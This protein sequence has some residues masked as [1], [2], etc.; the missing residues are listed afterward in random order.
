MDKKDPLKKYFDSKGNL[1][2]PNDIKAPKVPGCPKP[3]TETAE[4]S[5]ARIAAELKKQDLDILRKKY[6]DAR[7]DETNTARYAGARLG[8]HGMIAL[9]GTAAILKYGAISGDE[10][11]PAE[12]PDLSNL[13]AEL[14]S[15]IFLALRRLSVVTKDNRDP[16]VTITFWRDSQEIELEAEAEGKTFC[17]REVITAWVHRTGTI[18]VDPEKLLQLLGAWPMLLYVS[19]SD[20][21]VVMQPKDSNEFMTVLCT[22]KAPAKES[23]I[24]TA[25]RPI[26]VAA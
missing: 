9:D 21:P 1:K 23:L 16:F 4:K 17:G 12:P 15:D 20:K 8:N 24:S 3:R 7:E 14:N 10:T 26:A 11:F 19:D 13:Y 25:G 22:V 18:T 6:R 2:N 5:L